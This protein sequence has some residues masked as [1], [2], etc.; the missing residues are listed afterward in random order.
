M[1][2]VS[3]AAV[4]RHQV[5]MEALMG[6]LLEELQGIRSTINTFTGRY[7]LD[8]ETLDERLT[9]IENRVYDIERS[10]RPAG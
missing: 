4:I 9:Q 5:A 3:R 8:K 1:G 10:A 7:G 2:P 6:A